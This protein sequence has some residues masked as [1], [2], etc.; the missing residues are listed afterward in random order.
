[1]DIVMPK[2]SDERLQAIRAS[3]AALRR[4]REDAAPPDTTVTDDRA[5]SAHFGIAGLDQI[6]AGH[7][8]QQLPIGHIAP[9][10]RP[11][12]R[13]PRLLPL[14][15]DIIIDSAPAPGYAMLGAELLELGQ[16]L[17]ER[18]IQPIVV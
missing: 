2:K 1:M 12:S 4:P 11:E 10:L 6:T 16:S 13:Q 3:A 18:Q 7:V 14:P 5:L 8:V 15:E 17:K 9:D